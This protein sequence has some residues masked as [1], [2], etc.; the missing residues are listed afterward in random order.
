MIEIYQKELLK[1]A[2]GLIKRAIPFNF[3]PLEEGGQIRTATWDAVCHKYSY[4]GKS[5]KLEVA[6]SIVNTCRTDDTVEGYLIAEEIL[7]RIDNMF[8]SAEVQE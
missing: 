3:I 2:E 8:K 4:G 1:L 6:G 5:G 7:S